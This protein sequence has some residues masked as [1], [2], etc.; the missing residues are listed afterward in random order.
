MGTASADGTLTITQRA[1]VVNFGAG[2]AN[3]GVNAAGGTDPTALIIQALVV[4]LLAMLEPSATTSTV[5]ATSAA[6]LA[7][8]GGSG[9]ALVGTGTAIAAGNTTS[10]SITQLASGNVSGSQQASAEQN[11]AVGNFGLALGEHWSEPRRIARPRRRLSWPRFQ[12]C[13]RLS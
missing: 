13:S 11:A 4:A 3:T 2:I 1:V 12:T 5:S 7:A 10:T 9:T 6:A 8:S